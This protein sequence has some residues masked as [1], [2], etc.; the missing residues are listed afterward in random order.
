MPNPIDSF[1]QYSWWRKAFAWTFL[2][3]IVGV[4]L[5]ALLA[6]SPKEKEA[7]RARSERSKQFASEW[8][9]SQKAA[10]RASVLC[11]LMVEHGAVIECDLNFSGTRKTIDVTAN[12]TQSQAELFCLETARRLG[13][14]G[15]LNGQ[16]SMRIS[17]PYSQRPIAVCKLP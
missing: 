10:E 6:D 15:G 11:R 4:P 5:R 1:A 17:T 2:V 16:W 12:A 7:S 9:A 3:L 13:E 8:D 14:H